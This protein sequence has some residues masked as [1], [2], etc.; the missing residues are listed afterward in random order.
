MLTARLRQA[1]GDFDA[2]SPDRNW[3]TGTGMKTATPPL[4]VS[5]YRCAAAFHSEQSK[6][7]SGGQ[8][9]LLYAER[10]QPE[11]QRELYGRHISEAN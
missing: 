10:K 11:L 8:R 4:S 5:S 3:N 6:S 1:R 9:Q 7:A 2:P